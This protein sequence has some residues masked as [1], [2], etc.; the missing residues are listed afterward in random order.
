MAARSSGA[1][2]P[3]G[4]EARVHLVD[5]HQVLDGLHG[6][7]SAVT[8]GRPGATMP[9]RSP[10][11]RVGEPDLQRP[12]PVD[13]RGRPRRVRQRAGVMPEY[14]WTSPTVNDPGASIRDGSG[15]LG[16]P[17]TLFYDASRAGPMHL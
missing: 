13:R 1:R 11:P 16:Q 17:I 9:Q 2:L 10:A 7:P 4:P 8:S 12:C 5:H 14:G 15:L 3:A 6:E